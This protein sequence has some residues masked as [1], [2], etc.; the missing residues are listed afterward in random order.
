MEK[1]YS[2][3]GEDTNKFSLGGYVRYSIKNLTTKEKKTPFVTFLLTQYREA[4]E[5]KNLRKFSKTF[6]ILV[7]EPALVDM[8][9]VID[10][11][12]RVEVFGNL[13]IK[14]EKVGAFTKSYPTLIATKVDIV[15]DLGIPFQEKGKPEGAEHGKY[16]QQPKVKTKQ[17]IDEEELK[18]LEAQ[19]DELP[20]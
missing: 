14:V 19:V 5:A 7:F 3:V 6:Q 16:Y 1:T 4:G 11:Q 8:L 13:G 10:R 15:Q 9:R 12:I 18:K 17:E 20:F 2:K